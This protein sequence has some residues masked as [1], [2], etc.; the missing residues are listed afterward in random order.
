[1][2]PSRI[3]GVYP[4]D[5]LDSTA[6]EFYA[7]NGYLI[8]ENAVS[9]DECAELA[10]EA[11]AVCRGE[12][13]QVHRAAGAL[14][15]ELTSDMLATMPPQELIARFLCIHNPHKISPTIQ[16]FLS[17]RAIVETLTRV[18]GPNVK[19]MQSMLFV[20]SA[21]KP[22]QAWHQDEDY[23]PTR[24]R[25]LT[26][27]WIAIDDATIENGCLWVIPGS[28][29]RGVLYPQYP[30]NDPD[31]DC[32]VMSYNYPY[33]EEKDAIPVEVQAGA[34][35][36][37][38]GY[39]L[40]KSLPNRAPEGTFRRV[41]VNHYMSA[42]SVLPWG[43]KKDFRD[44]TLIAGEDPHAWKG[45]EDLQAA[46]VRSAGRGGCGDGRVDLKTHLEKPVHE[47]LND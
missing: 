31:Y 45:V 35:V 41:L 10:E 24:D 23:I 9:A 33:D 21:G 34:I 36:F 1:M 20:K 47:R 46:S 16:R 37:F 4:V 22:G 26:G 3:P 13:G 6:V 38:N 2:S 8:V 42:E 27:A 32:N 44:I 25:S 30:H 7:E 19:C 28:H 29:R 40:H 17:H 18:I 11:V 43:G 5:S 39:L 14:G 12:R 15:G